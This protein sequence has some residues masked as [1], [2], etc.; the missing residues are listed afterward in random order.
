VDDFRPT[1]AYSNLAKTEVKCMHKQ[2]RFRQ[3]RWSLY[4]VKPAFHTGLHLHDI[5]NEPCLAKMTLLA[6]DW[7]MPRRCHKNIGHPFTHEE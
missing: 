6:S 4:C 7:G 5:V 3:H 1:P 2:D